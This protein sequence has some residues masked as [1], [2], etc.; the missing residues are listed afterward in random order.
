MESLESCLF[1]HSAL[2]QKKYLIVPLI[3]QL[4]PNKFVSMY[5]LTI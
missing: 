3:K 2:D 5:V 4:D 1:F